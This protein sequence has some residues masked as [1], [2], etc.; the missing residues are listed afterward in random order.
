MDFGKLS[1]GIQPSALSKQISSNLDAVTRP[2]RP[3]EE[4]RESRYSERQD[5]N[6]RSLRAGRIY[7]EVAEKVAAGMENLSPEQLLDLGEY[8]EDFQQD[9]KQL[10]EETRARIAGRKQTAQAEEAQKK[11]EQKDRLDSSFQKMKDFVS[12]ARDKAPPETRPQ[13]E[14]RTPTGAQPPAEARTPTGAQAGTSP[15]AE[16]GAPA[17]AAS[18]ARPE[19]QPTANLARNLASGG[20]AGLSRFL[21]DLEKNP[22]NKKEFYQN[23]GRELK[24]PEGSGAFRNLVGDLG[25]APGGQ[26][27][28]YQGL[29]RGMDSQ[30]GR[31]VFAEVLRQTPR[32]P[33]DQGRVFQALVDSTATTAGRSNLKSFLGDPETGTALL[34]TMADATRTA[35]GRQQATTLFNN[36]R[37]D[38]AASAALVGTWKQATA[39]PEGLTDYRNLMQNLEQDPA[40]SRAC[41]GMLASATGTRE[42]LSDFTQTLTRVSRDPQA[43]TA[44]VGVL[45]R[46]TETPEGLAHFTALTNNLRQDPAASTAFVGTLA[47]ATESDDGMARTSRL[48]ANVSQDPAA[49]TS[50][51]GTLAS[52]SGTEE[53]R[54]GAARLLRNAAN[55]Q[56]TATALMSTLAKAAES[57][58]GRQSLGTLLDQAEVS[59]GFLQMA[60]TATREAQGRAAFDQFLQDLAQAPSALETLKK[61]VAQQVRTA[62]GARAFLAVADNLAGDAEKQ[63][64]LL[65]FLVPSS[66][67]KAQAPGTA[68]AREGWEGADTLAGLLDH[69]SRSG[70]GATSVARL[71]AGAASARQGREALGDLMAWLRTNGQARNDFIRSLA[72]DLQ[73]EAG[74]ESL[75]SLTN[76]MN[77]NPESRDAVLRTLAQATTSEAGRSALNTF[78]QALGAQPE[79]RDSM[80]GLLD[81]AVTGEGHRKTV[82]LLVANL[83]KSPELQATFLETVRQA[84]STPKGQVELKNLAAFLGIPVGTPAQVAPA[85]ILLGPP[86]T[87]GKTLEAPAS[88][89]TAKG[90]ADRVAAS[91]VLGEVNRDLKSTRRRT[92]ETVEEVKLE[93]HKRSAFEATDL[94]PASAF[95]AF[96]K[97]TNCGF[98][99]KA[100]LGTCPHC[101]GEGRQ[102]VMQTEV[103]YNFNGAFYTPVR[104]LVEF[105]PRAFKLLAEDLLGADKMVF[106][107]YRQMTPKF[108]QLLQ[109]VHLYR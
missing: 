83:A 87:V 3:L 66:T 11:L 40:A 32:T 30:E 49:S 92:S 97:C 64:T 51:V 94:F 98:E 104:D 28:L 5:I 105:T 85:V 60:S 29:T 4:A 21:D 75:R 103:R 67:G 6:E 56:A 90:Y 73:G 108:K 71:L 9:L 34:P 78:V 25:K 14:A 109:V 7:R 13:A 27:A 76:E 24:T 81:S 59:G 52:A 96:R 35:E 50:L 38:P 46:S 45:A 68:A 72:L 99:S 36:L 43:S 86:V 16:A 70:E 22:A 101:T 102:A 20:S 17:Q 47:R 37:Q 58:E 39:T 48:L 74:A 100:S 95:T 63:K 33:E 77:R 55:D 12:T 8:L 91:G 53:G 61:Q 54:A 44:T 19:G 93:G 80:L 18:P 26:A 82:N 107:R 10:V 31:Q 88:P 41:T 15:P 106:L 42:G 65:T 79:A 57:S 2:A 89:T 23:L 62:E 1:S 69:A 84:V